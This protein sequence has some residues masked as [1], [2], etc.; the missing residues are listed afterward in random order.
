MYITPILGVA[1]F[2]PSNGAV[3]VPLNKMHSTWCRIDKNNTCTRHIGTTNN[4][5]STVLALMIL[6]PLALIV[7][8][9][10]WTSKDSKCIKW[11]EWT[12][13]MLVQS[14]PVWMNNAVCS[15]REEWTCRPRG[16]TRALKITGGQ[17]GHAARQ[18]FHSWRPRHYIT[19]IWQRLLSKAM[20]SKYIMTKVA[21]CL[22][23]A[24]N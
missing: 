18:A 21:L 1:E 2:S 22:L 4:A 11:I 17:M 20:H 7:T 10:K 9:L 8:E 5:I 24:S 16:D 13:S 15:G 23:L 6:I 19:F 3:I 14:Y 12:L